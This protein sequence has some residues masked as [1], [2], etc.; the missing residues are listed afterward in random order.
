MRMTP[1]AWRIVA[2]AE[3]ADRRRLL[4][5]FGIMVV[6]AALGEFEHN[7]ALHIVTAGGRLVRIVDVQA[8]A[9]AIEAAL[10]LS[11]ESLR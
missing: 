4:D 1:Q 11:R 8:P 5:A 10:H 9:E 7:A 2:L 6:P 3:S